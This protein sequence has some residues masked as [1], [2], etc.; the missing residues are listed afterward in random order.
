MIILRAIITVVIWHEYAILN[1]C[2]N[3][4]MIRPPVAEKPPADVIFLILQTSSIPEAPEANVNTL[5]FSIASDTS[6]DLF[7]TIRGTKYL[8]RSIFNG[9]IKRYGDPLPFIAL[10]LFRLPV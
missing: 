8:L 4:L 6:P 5:F 10:R 9:I 2:H 7:S 3:Q 1:I